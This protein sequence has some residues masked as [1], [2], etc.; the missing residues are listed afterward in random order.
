M[1]TPYDVPTGEGT[2]TYEFRM[3]PTDDFHGGASSVTVTDTA[4]GRAVL[5][6][7]TWEH[8]EDG[9]QEGTLVLGVPG[10]DGVV[11]AA[12]VDSWHQRDVV[13]LTGTGSA[14]G[15]TVGYEY[16]PGWTWEIEVGVVDGDL[17]LVMRNGVPAGEGSPGGRYDV[18]RGRWS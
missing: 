13:L 9:P 2:G 3:M 18:M 17:A 5:V 14:A 16:A 12:W 10:E 15:A 11:T 4:R 1:T 6:A 8:A 7:Y